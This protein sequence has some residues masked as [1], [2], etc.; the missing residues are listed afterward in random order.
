M[1]IIAINNGSTDNSINILN[2]YN[3]KYLE[4]KII[5]QENKGVSAAINIWLSIAKGE[6]IYFLDSDV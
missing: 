3:Q 2:E 6:Y 5:N 1:G 4:I